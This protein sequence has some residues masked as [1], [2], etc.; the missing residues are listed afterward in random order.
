M[1]RI[2]RKQKTVKCPNCNTS[3]TIYAVKFATGRIVYSVQL[4]RVRCK[5]CHSKMRFPDF[6]E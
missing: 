3:N 4:D 6:V 5:N 1:S 2:I